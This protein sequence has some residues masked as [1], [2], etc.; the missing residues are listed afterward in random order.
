MFPS[1]RFARSGQ[2]IFPEPQ[3][4]ATPGEY[5]PSLTGQGK[6]SKSVEGS[7]I[8]LTDNLTTIKNKLAK[9]P[10]DSGQGK[11]VPTSGGV[12]GL[13]TF[14]ELFLGKDDRDEYE[15][16]YLSTGLRY[17]TLKEKLASAIFDELKPLQER[18]Q[19]FENK[20]KEVEQILQEGKIYCS[21]IAKDT[22][23]QVKQAM[24]LI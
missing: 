21:K 15:K 20:P 10:T 24:G 14:V 9:L 4:F 12:A 17:G 18:R 2:V 6:M 8:L 5:A 11:S 1:T 19:Y 3:R 23:V 22:L 7:Y 13:L 16:Q